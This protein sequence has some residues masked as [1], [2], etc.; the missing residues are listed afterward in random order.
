MLGQIQIPCSEGTSHKTSTRRQI[1]KFSLNL[2]CSAFIIFSLLSSL[3]ASNVVVFNAVP[4]N[5]WNVV[6]RRQQFNIEMYFNYF[7]RQRI[8]KCE[9]LL[10]FDKNLPYH[11]ISTLSSP[12]Q[13]NKLFTLSIRCRCPILINHL[14]KLQNLKY[15]ISH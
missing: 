14:I 6:G 1:E 11:A 15:S 10:L 12:V 13:N 7:R 4:L 8:T 5:S 9:Y 3:L 2:F